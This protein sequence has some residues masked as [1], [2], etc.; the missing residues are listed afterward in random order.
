M[1]VKQIGSQW[2][3][4]RDDPSAK[5]GFVVVAGPYAERHWAVSAHR[6]NEVD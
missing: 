5:P 4:T 2:Y 6:L 1:D 3:V